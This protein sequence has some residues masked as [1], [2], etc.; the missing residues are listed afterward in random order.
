MGTHRKHPIFIR[1]VAG[2]KMV[3]CINPLE[4][5]SFQIVEKAKVTVKRPDG[6]ETIE[7][8]TIRFFFPSGTGLTYTVGV[9]FSQEQF[10]YVCATLIEFLYM[11]EAEWKARNES[12]KQAQMDDWNKLSEENE[13]K[14]PEPPKEA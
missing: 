14:L 9:D 11:N 4:L 3:V 1:I 10:D 7:A 12:I 6:P 5:S 2:N 8:D 13:A